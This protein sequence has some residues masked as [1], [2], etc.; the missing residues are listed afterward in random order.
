[1]QTGS[2]LLAAC[3]LEYDIFLDN[4][5]FAAFIDRVGKYQLTM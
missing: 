2:H 1:M 5:V 3:N 4:V